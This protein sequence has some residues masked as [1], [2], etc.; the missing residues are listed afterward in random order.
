MKTVFLDRDGVISI[1]TPNDYIKNWGEFAFID[2]AIEGLK[3]LYS[4]GYR[5]V[6]ISN[7]SGINKG[8]FKIEDLQDITERMKN[9]LKKEGV[10]LAGV[11]Y[12]V[13]TSEED[14][15]CRKPKTGMF[16]KAKEE[17]GN[18]DF[19]R[20]YFIGDSDIDVIAGKNIGAK[21]VLVLT[22]KTKTKE[23]VEN[24]ETKPDYIFNNLKEAADFIIKRNKNG[25]V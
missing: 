12:C 13:H 22:G 5:L 25:K 17:I 18:I 24:W 9:I 2:G 8:L 10:E 20:T 11:Y 23:E 6:I 4:N 21:T 1:F 14:C 7:Q 15:D 16:M 19:Q 3:L